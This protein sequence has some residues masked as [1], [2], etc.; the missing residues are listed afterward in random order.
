[1]RKSLLVGWKP[2]L[3]GERCTVTAQRERVHSKRERE[4]E[5][6]RAR[7]SEGERDSLVNLSM[8]AAR[9]SLRRSGQKQVAGGFDEGDFGLFQKC[10]L[11]NHYRKARGPLPSLIV[12]C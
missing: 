4:R 2:D 6:E 10:S 12:I 11:A 9:M 3:L 7:E 8:H 1:M 5:R